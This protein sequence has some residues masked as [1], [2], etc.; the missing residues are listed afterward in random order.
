MRRATGVLAA[1][2]LLLAG[3]LGLPPRVDRITIVNPTDYDL[4][5]EVTGRD[6]DGWLPTAIVEAGE[7]DV[8]QEVIDQGEVW[9]FRFRHWG[10]PMGEL[11]ASRAELERSGWRVEV[12]AQVEERL[13]EL[14]RPSSTEVVDG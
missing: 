2:S 12:P 1:S 3:C 11:S 6:R 14:G 4:D 5:V 13:R 9:I 10:D 8:A 7:E